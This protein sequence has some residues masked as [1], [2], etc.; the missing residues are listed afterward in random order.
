MSLLWRQLRQ[1]GFTA[2]VAVDGEV[3]IGT[4]GGFSEYRCWSAAYSLPRRSK[5]R[6]P[7]RQ[8]R[9][10]DYRKASCL[11]SRMLF[12]V[13]SFASGIV[14]GV[15]RDLGV[16]RLAI[17]LPFVIDKHELFSQTLLNRPGVVGEPLR[18]IEIA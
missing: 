1:C 9:D 5:R 10:C 16:R 8:V 4:G 15:F 6:V 13:A 17:F 18:I 14:G 3:A 12:V 2:R 7:D 11:L